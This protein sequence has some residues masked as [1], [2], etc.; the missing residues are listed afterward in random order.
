MKT[1]ARKNT[2]DYW[3]IRTAFDRFFNNFFLEDDE[4]QENVRSMAI[5]LVENDK[6]YEVV[7]NLPG[8]KK[9][10]IKVSLNENELVIEAKQEE[11]KEEK[12]GSY[13]RC[14]RYSGN[15]RRSIALTDQCD[16]DSI[17]AK[18]EDGVLTL[19]IPK[20]EPVPAKEIK[21]K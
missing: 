20:K 6:D 21:I 11:K 19:S 3:P 15:Y 5:D 7:A 16:A 9:D 17:K 1:L 18:Y 8:I 13:Y 10:N 4:D 2:R 12:K 14:E